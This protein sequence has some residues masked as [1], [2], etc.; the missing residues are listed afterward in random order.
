[1][2]YQFI[3]EF[4]SYDYVP[5]TYRKLVRD[6][7]YFVLH[8]HTL[9]KSLVHLD[10]DNLCV[11]DD[12]LNLWGLRFSEMDHASEKNDFLLVY[13]VIDALFALGGR[14]S[15]QKMP[16]DFDVLVSEIQFTQY[17]DEFLLFCFVL[18]LFILFL[19]LY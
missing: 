8:L 14:T 13:S 9:G 5:E 12:E 10:L 11:R 7:I 1:M 15:N 17:V 18:F 2:T 6:L 16:Y 4:N 19:H 3:D